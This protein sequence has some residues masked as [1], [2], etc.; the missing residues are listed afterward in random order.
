MAAHIPFEETNSPLRGILDLATFCYPR[1]LFGGSL[2]RWLPVFHFHEVTSARLEPCLAYLAGNGYRTVTSDAIARYVREGVHPGPNSVA[3]CFDDAWASLCTVAAPLLR[4]YGFQAI[5]Y[6]SPARVPEAGALPPV[7]GVNEP[8]ATWEELRALHAS[9]TVEIQAHSLRHAM[10]FCDEECVG[11][12]TPETVRHI[13]LYPW[14]ATGAG[15]RFLTPDDLGAPLYI[16]RSR[17]SDAHRFSNPGAFETC[18]KFVRAE[19]GEEYFERPDWELEL[20]RLAHSSSGTRETSVQR[21]AAIRDDLGAARE[22]LNAKLGTNTV[23]HMCFPWAVAGSAA[24]RLASETG[25]ETAF[26]DRL[27][28]KRA[29]RP[30]DPPYRLMRLKHEYFFCLPGAPRRSFFA[31][32]QELLRGPAA[33]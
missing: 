18:T 11:F 4:R 15:D 13:H 20:R 19:G 31:V 16:E 25:Y 7:G 24:E 8:F 21:D 5:T 12:V 14:A 32:Q 10:I 2:G 9:G 17:Y 6:V 27:F 26:A 3:L 30:G 33:A 22:T 28:G 1:F 29:V 23:R